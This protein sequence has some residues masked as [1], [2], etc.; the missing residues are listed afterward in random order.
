[1]G[2]QSQR[3]KKITGTG[4]FLAIIVVLTLISNY[5]TFSI[6]G[7]NINLSL[8]VIVLGA[9]LYG[10]ISGLLLG[11]AN[12]V[13]TIFA[14]GTAAFLAINPVATVLLCILK[15]GL[16]GLASGFLFLLF[17]KKLTVLGTFLCSIIVPVINT[18]LFIAGV[19]LFFLD[20]FGD[21]TTLI[22]AVVGLNFLI[23]SIVITVLCPAIYYI[24]KLAQRIINNHNGYRG[25]NG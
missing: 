18:G 11:A 5:V 2:S 24:I 7:I 12:G 10:P 1:M 3:I 25:E 20:I 23:E 21:F 17:K 8:V 13:V 19:L 16:A 4:I 15:T 9:C 14:P 6:G 22:T